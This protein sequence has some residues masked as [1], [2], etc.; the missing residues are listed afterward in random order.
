MTL[1]RDPKDIHRI[2]EMMAEP[3][4]KISEFYRVG[5]LLQMI[6]S[7]TQAHKRELAEKIEEVKRGREGGHLF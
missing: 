6:E 3:E 5:N 7:Q 1:K 2:M 4:L